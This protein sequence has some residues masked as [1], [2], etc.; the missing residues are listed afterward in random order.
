M[1][2][3]LALTGPT[4]SGKTA[5]SLGIAE[6]LGC[7][8]ISCDSMQ[9]YRG[10]DIGTAKATA[11]ERARVPHHLIDLISPNE[12]YSAESYR[13]DAMTA[14]T[15]ITA[16]GKIP[17][18]VGGTGL[19]V[20][21]LMRSSS[22]DVPGSDPEYRDRM[23]AL[24]P[25][26]LWN[27]LLAIDPESAEKTHK[28]NTKRVI[29]ALEIYDATGKPKSYFDKLS[30]TAAADITIGMITIDFHDRDNLYR[31]VDARVD[32]MVGEGLIDEVE[33]LYRA[34]ALDGN[35][36]ASQAIGYKELIGYL[37]GEMTLS[38]ALESVKLASR[39]Y[40]KRQL[41]WFRHNDAE[42]IFADRE[43]GL[44]RP[45]DELCATATATAE[46]LY[47]K[48]SGSVRRKNIM[49][50]DAATEKKR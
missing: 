36:T 5:L 17:L 10:M 44:L 6:R 16:R 26:E 24:S 7:E 32:A 12:V 48:I 8:I 9:I 34:G 39:R 11:A 18:F 33:S 3:A 47:E 41:T 49:A 46:R 30:R 45:I 29:R 21:T 1:I 2:Y 28:N 43:D 42:R 25:D 38:D 22:P 20:D 4:A 23:L 35:N 13:Q 31:R 15:E 19:Y 40:A 27:R 50:A 14:A 37:K